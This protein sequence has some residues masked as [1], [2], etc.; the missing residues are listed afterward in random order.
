MKT[1]Q[2]CIVFFVLLFFIANSA[3]AVQSSSF[4]K[5]A[6]AAHKGDINTVQNLIA[7][8][9][10][11]NE[12]SKYGE[13][14]L[15]NAAMSG[16]TAIVK[17]LIDHGADIDQAIAQCEESIRWGKENGNAGVS[18]EGLL[19]VGMLKRFRAEKEEAKRQEQQEQQTARAQA[20][21][22]Q[23]AQQMREMFKEAVA[24]ASKAPKDQAQQVAIVSDI[25]KP[26]YHLSENKND[27]AIVVGIGKYSDISEAQF[28]ER[29]AEAVKN[30]LL[31]LGFPSRNVV[32]L[33]DEKAGYKG[34]EKFVEAW[35]PRNVDENS[36]VIFY[37]SGHGAPDPQTGQTYLLPYD[38]D[39]NFLEN[40]GY[41]I[42]R[43]YE[44]L[45]ILSAKEV[46]VIIDACFSGAGGR[47]VLPK[48]ARPLVMTVEKVIVPQ[49]LTVFAAAAGDQITSTLEDQG[50]G[51]FTY[52][53][54]KGLSGGAKDIS[55]VITEHGLYAYLR[56]KVQDAARRQN[57]N[58]EPILHA[59]GN[60]N[61]VRF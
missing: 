26:A 20:I 27:Y 29:D 55:G 49:K 42:Q 47:S 61:L 56:P 15:A 14:A 28:A 17:L 37:F 50:H 38:G 21:E 8:G 7:A 41:P 39:P 13:S 31:A 4:R 59:Q 54:L 32:H 19:G 52:Y 18:A 6:H 43:L 44:K 24:E 30:H 9:A 10:D 2:S 11:V 35:L 34:I 60:R 46:I 3:T 5:M 51:T 12:V 25:D 16:H 53:F 48:G 57:R 22:A 33:F 45:N 58:Q 23:R 40:T 1:L 36:R